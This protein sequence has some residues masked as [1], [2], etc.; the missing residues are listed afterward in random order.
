MARKMEE[1]WGIP[2]ISVS[3][4]GKRDTTNAIME[5]VKAFNDETLSKKAAE[6]IAGEEALCDEKLIPYKEL[7]RGKK[8]VLNTGGNKSWSFISALQDLGVDVVATAINKATEDD[9]EK[10]RE[11]LGPEG[12]LM[13]V[14]SVD[15]PKVI[16]EK[17][18]DILLAGGRSLYTALKN[19]IAFVDVNQEKKISYGGYDGLVNFAKDVADALNNPVFKIASKDAPWAK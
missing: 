12:V 10:A 7:F 9:V 4:Y 3:F 11:Y 16:K 19:K 13:K 6:V 2:W 14:P 5:I 18:A 17:G 8:A 1:K 15:Q